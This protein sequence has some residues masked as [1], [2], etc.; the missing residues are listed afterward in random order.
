MLQIRLIWSQRN[1]WVWFMYTPMARKSLFPIQRQNQSPESNAYGYILL[2]VPPHW[3]CLIE[4]VLSDRVYS[5]ILQDIQYGLELVLIVSRGIKSYVLM[6]K[7]LHLYIWE[8]PH[9]FLAE[10][11][12]HA[13][14]DLGCGQKTES[15]NCFR[16]LDCLLPCSIEKSTMPQLIMQH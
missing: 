16:I 15:I 1:V 10:S 9:V 8:M 2:R 7:I 12:Y 5:N 11:N 6:N 14:F 4:T 3:S 13:L